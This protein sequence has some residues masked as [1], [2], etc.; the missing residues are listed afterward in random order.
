MDYRV[1]WVV[2]L[3]LFSSGSFAISELDA[4]FAD[5]DFARYFSGIIHS[6]VE[7]TEKRL[8]AFARQLKL[9][10]AQMDSWYKFK[11]TF[12]EQAESKNKRRAKLKKLKQQSLNSLEVLKLRQIHMASRLKDTQ[13][14]I[15]V[16]EPLY[17]SLSNFQKKQFDN[18]MNYLWQQR[19]LFKMHRK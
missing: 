3:L 11:I 9:T 8:D 19:V 10:E 7:Q 6:D 5:E 4:D 18:V 2:M 1:F 15:E 14:L 17:Q 16:T 13:Q 12:L